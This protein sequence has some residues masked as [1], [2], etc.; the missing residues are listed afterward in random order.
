MNNKDEGEVL[1]EDEYDEATMKAFKECLLGSKLYTREF[2]LGFLH[3]PYF[4]DP[5]YHLFKHI[6]C[7]VLG[8]GCT[9]GELGIINGTVRSATSICK[10]DGVICI[11]DGVV[12]RD[13]LKAAEERKIEL[14]VNF[15]KERVLSEAFNYADILKIAYYFEKKSVCKGSILF[16]EKKPLTQVIILI[17]GEV[18]IS[19]IIEFNLLDIDKMKVDQHQKKLI[20]LRS[21]GVHQL[22]SRYSYQ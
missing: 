22:N 9:F 15:F 19:R 7:V 17:E 14:K 21:K 8:H 2:L 5:K 20:E 16:Q 12:Y 3:L 4:W 1:E 6:P 18:N 11:L 10:K 13:V